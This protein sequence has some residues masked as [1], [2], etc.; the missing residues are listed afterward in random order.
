MVVLDGVPNVLRSLNSALL[1]FRVKQDAT[2][3]KDNYVFYNRLVQV[4][5]TDT[6]Q[7]VLDAVSE[8]EGWELGLAKCC[9]EVSGALAN[10]MTIEQVYDRASNTH[11][12][13]FE[14]AEMPQEGGEDFMLVMSW[15]YE[16]TEPPTS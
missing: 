11:N 16:D 4:S 13:D 7:G 3:K 15:P 6:V 2:K 10:D 14:D 1:P 8:V 12:S 9:L 5:M